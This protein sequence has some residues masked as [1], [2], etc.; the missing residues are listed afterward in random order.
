M[1]HPEICLLVAIVLTDVLGVAVQQHCQS[2][3]SPQCRFEIESAG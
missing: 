2:E 1:G 3:P